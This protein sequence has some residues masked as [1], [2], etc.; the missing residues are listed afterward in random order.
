[1]CMQISHKQI[2]RN[3]EKSI[4]RR[5]LMAEHLLLL[6]IFALVAGNISGTQT[7]SE[8]SKR[9]CCYAEKHCSERREGDR[10]WP[11]SAL[12]FLA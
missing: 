2:R 10:S 5:K 11:S 3:S 8:S 6:P 9:F 4:Q 7:S 1:M 12:L